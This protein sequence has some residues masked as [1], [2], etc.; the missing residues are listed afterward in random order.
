MYRKK[1]IF[2]LH[3]PIIYQSRLPHR[4]RFHLSVD[5][6]D[7]WTACCVMKP[8]LDQNL[9][10][11]K[12]LPRRNEEE[13][14]SGVWT[15]AVHFTHTHLLLRDVDWLTSPEEHAHVNLFFMCWKIISLYLITLWTFLCDAAL[16]NDHIDPEAFLFFFVCVW[17]HCL[18]SPG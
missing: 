6:D 5:A 15:S 12:M 18:I 13:M 2:P 9:P 7:L 11:V 10:C 3:F 8:N 16:N 17:I 1:N 14:M 4:F